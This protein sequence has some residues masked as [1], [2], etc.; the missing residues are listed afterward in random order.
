MSKDLI[1]V[2]GNIEVAGTGASAEVALGREL[3]G[4]LESFFPKSATKRR[5]HRIIAS[6]VTQKLEG[7]THLDQADIDYLTEI[8]A[9][10]EVRWIRRKQIA[11][12]ALGI[13]AD[14]QQPLALPPHTDR[15]D[16]EAEQPQ[17]TSEDWLSRF[18]D[19]AG[20]VSDK[21]LQ[22]AYARILAGEAVKPGSCSM[23]TLKVLRYMDRDTAEQFAKL[24]PLVIDNEWVPPDFLAKYQIK[25]QLL[26]DLDEAGLIQAN[27]GTKTA[28]VPTLLF[29]Y[30][31]RILR[32]ENALKMSTSAYCLTRAG[33]ELA[34]VAQV[35]RYEHYFF[36]VARSLAA[37]KPDVQLSWA[38]ST[39]TWTGK[40]TDLT[41]QPIDR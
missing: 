9:D 29:S 5:L 41:W 25:Y 4:I 34:R 23:R 30:G 6:Q 18:R 39:D 38:T 24:L 31:Q 40:E 14:Q 28:I 35:Q 12:R 16:T 11:E 21:M 3:P 32:I 17:G 22:E 1:R 27:A 20:L 33:M 13:L 26:M 7:G 19:D 36:D 2:K 15:S 8:G 10:A 37:F